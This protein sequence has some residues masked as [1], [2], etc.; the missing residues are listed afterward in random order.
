M[1]LT[2][3]ARWANSFASWVGSSEQLDQRRAGRREAFGHLRC[4]GR[5]VLGRLSFE[6]TD[7]GAH[8]ARGDHE[9]REQHERQHRDLPR[10]AQHHDDRQDESDDVGHDAR[11]R[12]RERPL[13]AD[14]VVVQPA[15]ERAGVGSGEERDR[16]ALH[17]LEHPSSQ[18]EDESF[19]ESRRLRA[20]R[21]VRRPSRRPR[22]PRS[23]MASPTTVAVACRSTIALT[24]RP[25]NTGLA[26]PSTADPVARTRKAMI[27]RRCGLANAATR[28]TVSRLTDRRCLPSCCIALSSA[29]HM[30]T[31]VTSLPLSRP[32]RPT[33]LLKLT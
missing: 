21:G 1:S 18:V 22:W 13:G 30:L 29:I 14:H 28:R 11:Q 15:D 16:H 5:V 32:R 10:Q 7:L 31:S 17:V 23:S 25:A 9:H 3:C 24:A 6:G 2:R 12:R 20:V 33:Y 8:P 27:V 4:H 26:T 19:A